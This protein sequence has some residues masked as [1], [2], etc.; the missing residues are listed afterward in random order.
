MTALTLSSTDDLSDP[1]NAVNTV[2]TPMPI[3]SADAV[4]A[5]RRGERMALRRARAPGM[6][7]NREIG[8][9]ITELAGRATT[10]PMAT[11]PAA[12]SNAPRAAWPSAPLEAPV[13]TMKTPPASVAEPATRRHR[14]DAERS[15][16]TSRNAASGATRDTRALPARAMRAA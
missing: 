1:A 9:P 6:R 10:G 14:D 8:A 7:R 15:T 11:T 13:T 16:A 12:V 2:T 5:V 4:A 3:I